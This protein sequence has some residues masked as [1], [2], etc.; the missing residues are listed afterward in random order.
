MSRYTGELMFEAEI[1]WVEMRAAVRYLI[2]QRCLVIPAEVSP[3]ETWRCIAYNIS[4]TGIGV[5]LPMEVPERTMLTIRPWNLPGALP[6]QAVVVH[7][8]LVKGS[9]F[10]G[11]ELSKRLSDDEVQTWRS[12]PVDWLEAPPPH[13]SGAE[14]PV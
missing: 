1:S 8:Q 5:A 10:A 12:G 9:W 14:H 6:L 3:S 11:C 7:V 13:G 4:A 2:L